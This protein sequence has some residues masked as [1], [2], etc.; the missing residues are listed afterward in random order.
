[1]SDEP[2]EERVV[3]GFT[4][5]VLYDQSPLN[6]REDWDHDTEILYTSSRYYLGDRQVSSDEMDDFFENE[7]EN[8]YFLPVYAYIHSGVSL[9]TGSF[10]CPWDSGMCGI[11]RILKETAREMWG[12]KEPDHVPAGNLDK[13]YK[14]LCEEIR[15][16]P[17]DAATLKVLSRTT[18]GYNADL[19]DGKLYIPGCTMFDLSAS[20]MKF[21]QPSLALVRRM[22][23]E[24]FELRVE[25]YLKSDVEVFDKYLRGEVYGYQTL[26]SRGNVYGSC[27]S[28]YGDIEDVFE[29]AIAEIGDDFDDLDVEEA[30]PV[31]EFECV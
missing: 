27:W 5:Q 4:I 30:L 23:D 20:E 19:E 7:K 14:T 25:L 29:E 12:Y 2:I 9:S 16:D 10:G 15:L 26:D 3:N 24:L 22:Y 11:I 1:M 6:P 18:K 8:Y 13:I 28:F 31:L 21:R 17:G